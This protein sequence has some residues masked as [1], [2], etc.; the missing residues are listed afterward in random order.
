MQPNSQYLNP[1]GSLNYDALGITPPTSQGHGT[2]ADIRANMQRATP[3]RWFQRGNELVADTDL[4]EVV[5]LLPTDIHLTGVD[6]RNLPI[7][8]KM[9]L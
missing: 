5:N 7:L 6:D 3:I 9:V 2:E 1:D 8:T 4:G